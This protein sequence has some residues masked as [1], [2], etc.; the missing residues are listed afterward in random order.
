MKRVGTALFPRV[1]RVNNV[2]V[3]YWLGYE[4]VLGN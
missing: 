1:Y 3:I 4:L 2:T